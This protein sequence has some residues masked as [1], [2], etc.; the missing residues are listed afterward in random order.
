MLGPVE[1]GIQGN[2]CSSG[3]PDEGRDSESSFDRAF[4]QS[5]RLTSYRGY[6]GVI[7]EIW[8]LLSGNGDAQYRVNAGAHVRWAH[9]CDGEHVPG[10]AN[11]YPDGYVCDDHHRDD[12][13]AHGSAV[14]A[15][16]NVHAVRLAAGT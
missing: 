1:P 6:I 16:A 15:Y 14:R 5:V 8:Q 9:R 12:V 3:K 10:A 7:Y 4:G 2:S 11:A 13:D